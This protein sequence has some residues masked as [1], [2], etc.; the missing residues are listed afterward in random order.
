MLRGLVGRHL[1]HAEIFLR[2]EMPFHG[3]RNSQGPGAGKTRERI[4]KSDGWSLFS[5]AEY[6]VARYG[7][8]GGGEPS[9]ALA[10]ESSG[11]REFRKIPRSFQPS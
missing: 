3:R 5:S 2:N 1:H 11:F 10:K 4:H 8:E 9:V 7:D 6:P